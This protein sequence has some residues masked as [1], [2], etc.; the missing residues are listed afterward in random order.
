M[1]KITTSMH[2]FRLLHRKNPLTTTYGRLPKIQSWYQK[3]L[4]LHAMQKHHMIS[5]M[6]KKMLFNSVSRKT[7]QEELTNLLAGP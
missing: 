4:R 5:L 6:T 2:S 7:N 3:E 1:I